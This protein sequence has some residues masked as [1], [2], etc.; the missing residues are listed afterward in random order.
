MN[1]HGNASTSGLQRRRGHATWWAV[2]AA[3]T[4]AVAL[5]G[6]LA[7]QSAPSSDSLRSLEGAYTE[8]Q[9]ER[10]AQAFGEVCAACHAKRLFSDAAFRR[11]W[12]GRPVYSL[13]RLIQSTMPDDR[14]GALD[15]DAY[16]DILAYLFSLNGVPAGQAEL[17]ADDDALRTIR[18]DLSADSTRFT[19]IDT[20]R[21]P[22]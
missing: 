3:A 11:A 20:E 1:P 19:R 2:C 5:A 4:V 10:G 18:M 9:A 7:A 17:P 21:E 13:F 6:S 15:R 22:A 14:P 8:A 12:N 16:V